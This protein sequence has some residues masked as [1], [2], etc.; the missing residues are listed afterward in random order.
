MK[1]LATAVALALTSLCLLG[2]STGSA[3]GIANSGT[4]A[5]RMSPSGLVFRYYG[6]AGWHFQPLLSFAH[7]N[8]LVSAGRAPA[9]QR[10]VDALLAHGERQGTALYWSYDFPYQDGSAPWRS[11]FVQAIAAQSLAR[12]SRLLGRP[13]LLRP[14]RAALRGLRHGLLLHVGGGRWIREY[15]FSRQVILNAQLESLLSLGSYA[16]LVTTPESTRLV[17]SLYRATVRL[18]P[19]FDLGCH[20]RYQLGGRAANLHYQ[21]YHVALLRQLA[22]RY[23]EEPLFRRLH[24]RWRNCA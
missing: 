17:R 7:L 20:S 24:R 23:P 21:R 1:H 13:S 2:A 12:A 9:A 18:L 19:R 14:A 22:D 15:G 11:G 3:A 4:K 10:L 16:G 5:D 8:K 6:G